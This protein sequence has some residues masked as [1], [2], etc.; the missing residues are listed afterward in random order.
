M[1]EAA[2]LRNGH[3]DCVEMLINAEADVNVISPRGNTTLHSAAA[4]GKLECIGLLLGQGIQI[5]CMNNDGQNALKVHLTQCEAAT[6]E[7]S[8]LLYAAGET[9]NNVDNITIPDSLQFE[10]IK[11]SLKH[12]ARKAIRRYLINLAP[13]THLFDRIPRRGLPTM[14]TRYLLHNMSIDSQKYP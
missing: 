7:A 4:S 10:E 11:T 2:A 13:H 12:K 8:L 3:T 6:D 1:Y 14:I 9:L 5:N